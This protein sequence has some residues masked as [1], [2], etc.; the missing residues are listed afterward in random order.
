[1]WQINN[2]LIKTI[3]VITSNTTIANIRT[4][5]RTSFRPGHTH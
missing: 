1:M 2:S 3:Y 4:S 5:V